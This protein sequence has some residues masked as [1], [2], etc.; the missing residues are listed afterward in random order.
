MRS[1][2]LREL[3]AFHQSDVFGLSQLCRF[4]DPGT[5]DVTFFPFFSTAY[6]G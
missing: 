5:E 6:E 1:D 3:Q 2:P 4:K